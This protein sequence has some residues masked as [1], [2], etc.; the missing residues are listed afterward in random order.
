MS[1][2]K[3]MVEKGR[4]ETEDAPGYAMR[5]GAG[6]EGFRVERSKLPGLKTLRK[7]WLAYGNVVCGGSS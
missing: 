6:A 7:G 1:P 5:S 4:L 3:E 2:S